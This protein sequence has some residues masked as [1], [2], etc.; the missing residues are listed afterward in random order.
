MDERRSNPISVRGVLSR[1]QSLK[2]A[3]AGFG[4]LALSG[5]NLVILQRPGGSAPEWM[6]PWGLGTSILSPVRFS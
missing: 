4:Y 5:I 3:S 6:L 2:S 1:R